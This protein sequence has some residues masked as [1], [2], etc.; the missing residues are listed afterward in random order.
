[1]TRSTLFFALLAT[2]ALTG[3]LSAQDAPQTLFV[4]CN[5]FDGKAAKPATVSQ[6]LVEGKLI[7]SIGNESLK[8]VKGSRVIDCAGRTLMP[9]FIDAHVHLSLQVNYAELAG[10]DA[11]YFA[12]TQAREAEKMLMRGF[13]TARD[14]GGNV[15]SLKRVVDEG[16]FP[17]P[18]IYPSGAAI[19]Q[20]G[21]HGDYRLPNAPSR[22]LVNE[23]G[24]AIREG[25]GA[26]ADGPSQMLTAVRE[27]LRRGASQIKLTVGGGVASPADPLDTV[28]YTPEEIRAAVQGAKNWN[29]YVAAHVYNSD[30]IRQ[31]VENGIMSIEHANFIDE[32]TLDLVDKKGVWLSVQAMVFVNTPT[33]VSEEVKARFAEALT[34]L[35]Q[36]FRL[37]NKRGFKR[38]AFGTDVIAD[39]T[40]MARQNEEFTLRARWFKPAEILRQATSGNAELLALSGPRN[41]YPGKL[42]VIEEGAYAD[43]LLINGDPLKDISVLT[44]PNKN[45]ALIMKDGK[46]YKNSLN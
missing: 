14:V 8:A 16:M 44:N 30:G 41:P 18:R 13:T 2:L 35:D 32:E 21:G 26:L 11:Y 42:G 37:I 5:I 6:V 28:Q 38:V 29:T 22:L 20:T 19:S 12:F 24:P 3:P 31:A 1:M 40:L 34:G 33:S 25:V 23:P 36:M 7:K 17:G 46:I 10:L 15:F 27:N 43:L 39:P 9:G 4:N 45:L